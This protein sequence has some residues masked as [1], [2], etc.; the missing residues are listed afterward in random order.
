MVTEWSALC[1]PEDPALVVPWTD[2]TTNA[3][4]VDLRKNPYDFDEIPEAVQHPP[5]LQA[6]R[7]LN[8]TRSPVFTAKSD[9]WSLASEELEALR[10]ELDL[11]PDDARA[12]AA[13]YIDL[14][15]RE[16]TIFTSAAHQQQR[17]GRLLRLASRLD[18]P[19]ATLEC[20]LRPALLDL[21]SAQEGYAISLYLKA[22][23]ADQ[24]NAEIAWAAA[25][26]DVVQLI[27]SRE[28][29]R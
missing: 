9:V 4:F 25:L 6:L 10:L 24:Q 15:F 12:G 16:K 26:S 29:S 17:I 23:G 19:N 28:L 20:T 13:S 5:L 21:R 18:H 7:A 27:R 2:P 11:E 1:S 8:A 14:M 3:A 22:V